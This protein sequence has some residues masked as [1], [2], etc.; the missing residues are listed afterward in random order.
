MEFSDYIWSCSNLRKIDFLERVLHI[1]PKSQGSH[2]L[3][4]EFN[5]IRKSCEKSNGGIIG[6]WSVIFNAIIEHN[7][8]MELHLGNR[9][10][11]LV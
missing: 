6:R 1:M 11:T 5:I 2:S 7:N 9:Q 8:L 10:Y 3:W 4:G